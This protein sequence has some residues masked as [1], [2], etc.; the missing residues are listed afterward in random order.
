MIN[1]LKLAKKIK[2]IRCEIGMNQ[3]D[4]A[5]KV[6]LSRVALSQLEL[7]KRGLG[8]LELAKIAHILGVSVDYLLQDEEVQNNKQIKSNIKLFKLDKEKLKNVILY[9]LEKCGGKPNVGETVLYKL[10]YFLDFDHYELYNIPI[11]G[12]NYKKMQFGPAPC[13][14]DYNP[15]IDEMIID[16]QLEIISQ[17]YHGMLQKRYIALKNCNINVFGPTEIKVIDSVISRLSDMSAKQ[18]ED[19]VHDDAPWR[20]S[21]DKEFINY[22]LVFFRSPK[23]SQ[24]DYDW[25]TQ[26]STGLDYLKA[27]NISQKEYDYYENL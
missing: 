2:S 5:K 6:G 1:Q 21:Q 22:D 25:Q 18:I 26:N 8:A 4:F 27:E 9:I 11:T 10:L 14:H 19:Y 20:Q 15:V 3:Q 16:K 7:N 12:I 17:S 23:F 13:S 24:R